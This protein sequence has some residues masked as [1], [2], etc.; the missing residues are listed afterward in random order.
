LKECEEEITNIWKA[1][2][3]PHIVV[4]SV[5]YDFDRLWPSG[6]CNIPRP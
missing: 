4:V 1:Y 5:W 6:L 3:T 2:L